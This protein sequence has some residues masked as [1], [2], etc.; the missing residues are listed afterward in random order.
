LSRTIEEWFILPVP[1]QLL[2][3]NLFLWFYFWSPIPAFVHKMH[4]IVL[5]VCTGMALLVKDVKEEK[6]RSPTV[7]LPVKIV[8]RENTATALGQEKRAEIAR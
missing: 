8:R 5:Q 6:C 3:L 1:P 4:P 2:T 7:Q